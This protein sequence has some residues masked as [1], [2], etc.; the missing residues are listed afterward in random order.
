MKRPQP[1][2]LD[3]LDK[4]A[5]TAEL[6]KLIPKLVTE[7]SDLLEKPTPRVTRRNREEISN[8]MAWGLDVSLPQLSALESISKDPKRIDEGYRILEK[9]LRTFLRRAKFRLR[10]KEDAFDYFVRKTASLLKAPYQLK[11]QKQFRNA[12]AGVEQ[13]VRASVSAKFGVADTQKLIEEFGRKHLKEH[14]RFANTIDSRNTS[15]RNLDFR[16]LTP[17]NVTRITDLY[18]DSAAG[19]ESRLRLLVGLNYIA[20]GKKKTYVELR[21]LGYN[22]LLQAVESPRNS[23]LH[24]LRDSIDRHVRNAMMHGGVSS[25]VSKN[26]ITFID[27]SPSKQKETEVPWTWSEFVRRTKNLVVT[28]LAVGYLEHEFNYLRLYCTVA[29]FKDLRD[30]QT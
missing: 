6:E 17:R 1:E 21:K 29:A 13:L 24:F 27:Y 9:L 14:I 5:F 30:N 8:D 15:Y 12:R 19:F 16:R 28:I 18:H 2:S 20:I 23:L 7:M 10:P 25:S 11:R 22:Q 3:S 26:Q 4:E